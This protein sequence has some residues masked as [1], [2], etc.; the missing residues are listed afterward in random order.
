[1]KSIV[2]LFIILFLFVL[3]GCELIYPP[4][5]YNKIVGNQPSSSGADR[6]NNNSSV[7]GGGSS[8]S[9]GSGTWTKHAVPSGFPL[10]CV[11]MT[12]NNCI[13][14]GDSHG[15]IWSSQDKGN[16]WSSYNV[17]A[18]LSVYS[19]TWNSPNLLVST[20][21]GV[22]YTNSGSW[23][24]QANTTG[25]V[26]QVIYAGGN[27]IAVG[28][29]GLYP[30]STVGGTWFAVGFGE[31]IYCV[32]YHSATSQ[33]VAVGSPEVF[34][35]ASGSLS[36]WTYVCASSGILPAAGASIASSGTSLAVVNGTGAIFY[37]LDDGQSWTQFSNPDYLRKVIWAGSSFIAVGN[38]GVI[39]TST[40]AQNWAITNIG[41]TITE[42]LIDVSVF[43]SQM[44]FI[45]DQ[46]NAYVSP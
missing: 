16:S 20:A 41:L 26:Y 27:Y 24:L 13:L 46:L 17:I 35:N 11:M 21:A 33:Y 22:Y 2:S 30:S 43:G 12:N 14:I 32:C 44:V 36:S 6:G 38:A 34:T 10:T 19:F 28:N 42:N 1:M 7:A 25:L 4:Q 9:N 40:D 29:N 15:D 3:T 39:Y 31:T 23:T 5:F 45:D 8:S 37:S 18:S